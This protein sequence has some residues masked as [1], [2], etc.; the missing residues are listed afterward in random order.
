MQTRIEIT[1]AAYQTIKPSLGKRGNVLPGREPG[2]H[3]VLLFSDTV[4][5]LERAKRPGESFSDVILRLKAEKES[6]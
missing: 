5:S 1:D 4:M 6:R 2:T 3:R